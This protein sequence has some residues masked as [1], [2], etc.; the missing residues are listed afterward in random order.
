MRRLVPGG[1]PLAS[2]VALVVASLLLALALWAALHL[3]A[4]PATTPT[5]LSL[6]LARPLPPPEP[7]DSAREVTLASDPFSPDR[8]LPGDEPAEA[9][10]LTGDDAPAMPFVRLVGTVVR[11]PRSFAICQLGPEA[12]RIV[13]LGEK[14]GDLTLIS[15]EQGRAVFRATNGTRL[16]LSLSQP[17]T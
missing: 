5:D 16:E 17:G 12:P 7:P 2:T 4:A 15:L 8:E 6:A 11:G 10:P 13:H 1:L 3:R 9:A 14:L